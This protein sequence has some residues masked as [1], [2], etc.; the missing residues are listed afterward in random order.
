[1]GSPLWIEFMFVHTP[2]I[3]MKTPSELC[4]KI[5]HDEVTLWVKCGRKYTLDWNEGFIWLLLQVPSGWGHPFRV[6][7]LATRSRL[8]EFLGMSLWRHIAVPPPLFNVGM[9]V[10]YINHSGNVY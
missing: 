2:L 1:M 7:F 6:E 5:L 8:K 4:S 9:R 3:G 10:L